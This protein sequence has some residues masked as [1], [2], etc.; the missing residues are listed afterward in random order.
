MGLFEEPQCSILRERF[1]YNFA[2]AIAFELIAFEL[3]VRPGRGT[4]Q[5][6]FA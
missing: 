2:P 1:P 3:F 4:I 6:S 5:S